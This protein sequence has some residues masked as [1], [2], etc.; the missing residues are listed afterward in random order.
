[1]KDK[2]MRF[3]PDIIYERSTE[4]K[5]ENDKRQNN[6]SA[7]FTTQ[8]EEKKNQQEN[9]ISKRKYLFYSLASAERA[10]Y[11]KNRIENQF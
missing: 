4:L 7:D 8:K 9:F 2:K 10:V 5:K 6:Q 1:M 3:P 11:T